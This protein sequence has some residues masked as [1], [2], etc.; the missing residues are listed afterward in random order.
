MGISEKSRWFRN[1]FL[2][3]ILVDMRLCGIDR[4]SKVMLFPVRFYQRKF[5]LR[6]KPCFL[7]NVGREEVS[8]GWGG[9]AG[10]WDRVTSGA[11]FSKKS[12][13]SVF[14]SFFINVLYWSQM[15]LNSVFLL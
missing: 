6:G 12:R 13:F 1:R 15:H 9:R 14:F 5:F 7:K 8:R 10:L 11:F 4:A 2:R 3:K